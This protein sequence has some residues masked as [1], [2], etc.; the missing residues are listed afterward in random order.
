MF[1]SA[2]NFYSLDINLLSDAFHVTFLVIG[3]FFQFNAFSQFNVIPSASTCLNNGVSFLVS[4]LWNVLPTFSSRYLM[5][6]SL[7]LK[8]LTHF[9]LTFMQGV[10]D[11]RSIFFLIFSQIMNWEGLGLGQ[12]ERWCM[13]RRWRP[14]EGGN[15]R[16]GVQSFSRAKLIA[17][18]GAFRLPSCFWLRSS[19]T[20]Q[21]PV[22]PTPAAWPLGREGTKPCLVRGGGR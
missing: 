19:S 2:N 17:R 11:Q 16:A 10:K 8:S 1:S 18:S 22:P 7:I 5:L 12:Q 6:S 9:D 20:S 15:S 13:E 3:S 4:V 14:R 21:L